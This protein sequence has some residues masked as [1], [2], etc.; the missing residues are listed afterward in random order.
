MF[1]IGDK[2]IMKFSKGEQAGE[3]IQVLY[4]P[5]FPTGS[6]MDD[7]HYYSVKLDGF[8][9]F[10]NCNEDSIRLNKSYYRDNKLNKLLK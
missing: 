2:V 4:P 8:D 9:G 10:I 1:K 6:F 7:K 3:V 5:L